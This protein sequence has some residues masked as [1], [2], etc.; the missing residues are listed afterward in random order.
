MV[1]PPKSIGNRTC[2]IK[3]NILIKTHPFVESR[4]EL[5]PEKILIGKSMRMSLAQ[6][7][8]PVLWRGFMMEKGEIKNQIG[9]NLYSIQVYDGLQYFETF[10]PTTEFTK[11]AATEVR[12]ID[13]IPNGFSYITLKSGLYAVF[14]H[15]GT[16]A[17]FPRTFQY[18]FAQ[19]LPKSG[20]E[21]DDRPHFELLG[22]RYRNNDPS[23][24]EE[25][26][27]PIRKKA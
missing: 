22:E 7:R 18:I 13:N 16:S 6:N 17:D 2:A 25:V 12:K 10:S 24:E 14:V 9:S 20:Y 11:W 3:R 27:I 4:I 23:S 19:W 1:Y 15:K 26:W 5:L 8:T 21:L